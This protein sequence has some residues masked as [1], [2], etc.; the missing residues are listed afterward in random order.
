MKML[1]IIVVILY[2]IGS[3]ISE[4]NYRTLK[5]EYGL[6]LEKYELNKIQWATA[7]DDCKKLRKEL[8]DLKEE[9]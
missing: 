7:L 5:K 8:E 6:L 4:L 1:L 9:K 3:I 2:T